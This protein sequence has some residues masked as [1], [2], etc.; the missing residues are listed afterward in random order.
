[1]S[2]ETILFSNDSSYGG[3]SFI[4]NTIENSATILVNSVRKDFDSMIK[5]KFF[6]KKNPRLCVNLIQKCKRLI[7]F[8]VIS[9]DN[10]KLK[11]YRDK[12][13]ILI[14]SDGRFF[15]E[16]KKINNFLKNNPYI[17]VL[18][19]PDKIPFLDKSIEYKPY[20]QHINIP[21]YEELNKFDELTFSHSPGLKYHSN[22]KG[23]KFIKK[24]LHDQKLIIIRDKKWE[25]CIKIKEKTHIFIDQMVLKS[26]GYSK[27]GFKGGI[28]KSGLESMLLKNV[29]ITSSP[30]LI[31]EPFFEN[32]PSISIKPNE[33]RKTIEGFIDD[34]NKIKTIS[35]NQYEWARVHTSE[36]FVKNNILN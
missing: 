17:K 27:Y 13:I 30:Q 6:F 15:K 28:G 1:M 7:I 16:N 20:F 12:E 33:L 10:I 22:L 9:L 4:A 34:P 11:K 36:E 18:I 24:T 2:V 26:H 21:P 5:N 23:S 19:M 32:P 14:I 3:I 31:T 25:D 8:G 35:N 29:L